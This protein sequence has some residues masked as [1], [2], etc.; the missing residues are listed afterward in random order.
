[1]VV[2]IEPID[3]FHNAIFGMVEMPGIQGVFLA[4]GFL[5]Y[6]VIENQ[7]AIDWLAPPAARRVSPSSI[8]D[9]ERTHSLKVVA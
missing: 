7:Y 6:G 9:D 4:E 3:P 1:M 8:V 5:L 2:S